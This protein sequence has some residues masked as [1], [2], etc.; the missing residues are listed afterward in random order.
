[1]EPVKKDRAA[2]SVSSITATELCISYTRVN[3]TQHGEYVM[4]S[5]VRNW[6]AGGVA[7]PRINETSV[8]GTG[9]SG[10]VDSVDAKNGHETPQSPNSSPAELGWDFPFDSPKLTR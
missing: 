9:A 1:M 7:G 3:C 6:A 10:T 5:N 4:A 8:V 2:R